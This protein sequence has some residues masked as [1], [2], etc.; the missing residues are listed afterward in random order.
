MG[1]LDQKDIDILQSLGIASAHNKVGSLE[2]RVKRLEKIVYELC[3]EIK[4]LQLQLD[5]RES[6]KSREEKTKKLN[7]Q[8]EYNLGDS[9]IITEDINNNGGTIAAGTKG[10]IDNKLASMDGIFYI[11]KLNDSASTIKAKEKSFELNKKKKS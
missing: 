11:I 6:K 8:G 10:I 3:K 2:E 4:K 9:V 5:D 7:K 1:L